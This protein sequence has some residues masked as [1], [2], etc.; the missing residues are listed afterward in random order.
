MHSLSSHQTLGATVDPVGCRDQQNLIK[1]LCLPLVSLQFRGGNNNRNHCVVVQAFIISHW[2]PFS[3]FL[4]SF[5]ALLGFSTTVGKMFMKHMSNLEADIQPHNTTGTPCLISFTHAILS[6]NP[7]SCK[8]NLQGLA[9]PAP[10]PW[11]KE[12]LAPTVLTPMFLNTP[13]L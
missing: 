9:L 4:T 7:L 13:Q 8:L 3:G 2:N 10:T 12:L 1:P 5:L 6:W 11:W